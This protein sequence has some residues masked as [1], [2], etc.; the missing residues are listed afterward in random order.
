MIDDRFRPIGDIDTLE[1]VASKLPVV[2][3]GARRVL[4]PEGKGVSGL[5]GAGRG[6]FWCGGGPSGQVGVVRT[7]GGVA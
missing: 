3:A 1:L 2:F 7:P 5:E 4:M 6:L